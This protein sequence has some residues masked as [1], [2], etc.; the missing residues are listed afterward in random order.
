MTND[1]GFSFDFPQDR[2]PHIDQYF[3]IWAIREED[4]NSLAMIAQ[5]INITEHLQS[6]AAL[7]ARL[8]NTESYNEGQVA[9]VAVHG[10]L[11]KH[12]ASMSGGTSTVE[13][14]RTLRLLEQDPD[15]E[16]IVLHIDSPGGTVAGTQE[17]A[18]EIA[19]F[20]K[21]VVAFIEDLGAS[22]A[23][24]IASQAEEI[25]ANATA[26]V[27]S[28]GTYGV[29]VD[30]SKAAEE[31][32]IKVHVVKAGDFKG[33]G[34]LGTEV[35]EEQLAERQTIVDSLNQFFV[36]SV[37]RGRKKSVPYIE[38]MADGRVHIADKAKEYELIDYVGTL[39]DAVARVSELA[40][41]SP[42]SSTRAS[43]SEGDFMS[44][45]TTAE[46][47]AAT[48]AEIEAACSGASSDFVLAQMK[49]GATIADAKEAFA[50]HQL[51]QAQAENERLRADLEA[52][53]AELEA[54]RKKK[55]EAVH[56]P[57]RSGNA[58]VSSSE[59]DDSVVAANARDEWK[60]ATAAERAR[61]KS[62]A[63]AIVAVDK[64]HPG[65]RERMLEDAR[66]G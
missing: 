54:E 47:V 46:P 64:T 61:G 6:D 1:D 12:R 52:E 7:Q 51:E 56:A 40:S 59:A 25:F 2:V 50:A 15:I 62:A 19:S 53:R 26:L 28:I 17:L 36:E 29:V 5:R 24:W 14:R 38:A 18:D 45:T 20:S 30:A 3:G 37:A 8:G 58:I 23:Y 65:L 27:G 63:D 22:A 4:F 49:A 13:L 57:K 42:A 41:R 55:A 21:P 43:T 48:I 9:I 33:A 44:D 60:A 35:T 31:Q 66:N 32:G 34:V 39:G 10:S 11:M 16:G